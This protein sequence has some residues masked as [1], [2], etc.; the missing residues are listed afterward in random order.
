MG[1]LHY[2]LKIYSKMILI[3]INGVK[4]IKHHFHKN[5]L[6]KHLLA[7]KNENLKICSWSIQ[8]Y[9]QFDRKIIQFWVVRVLVFS[10]FSCSRFCQWENVWST[11]QTTSRS[12][13]Q[14]SNNRTYNYTLPMGIC[15]VSTA[16][17]FG[18]WYLHGF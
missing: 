5:L 3:S 18:L 12:M 1:I 4:A 16:H 11:F 17:I 7:L 6:R 10:T 8:T 13:D 9:W 2:S 14:T 15:H